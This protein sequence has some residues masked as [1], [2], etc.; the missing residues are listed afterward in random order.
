MKNNF[1]LLS[2]KKFGAEN[3]LSGTKGG[4]DLEAVQ[5]NF[6]IQFVDF[7]S[8]QQCKGRSEKAIKI[9]QELG[10]IKFENFP[11]PELPKAIATAKASFPPH[12]TSAKSH[13]SC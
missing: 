3:W 10:T 13:M 12:R 11:S 2:E 6:I 8:K 7:L 4:K 9:S 5:S 1:V